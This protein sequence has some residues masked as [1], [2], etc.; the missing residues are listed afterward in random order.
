MAASGKHLL[1]RAI[2]HRKG[3]FDGVYLAQRD[4]DG[5]HYAE[6]DRRRKIA[7]PVI[8]KG[9]AI[10]MRRPL[11]LISRGALR[12]HSCQIQGLCLAA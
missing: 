9:C 1:L 7:A 5:L 2:A 6:A 3:K 8:Q 11:N 4:E 12:A 10:E